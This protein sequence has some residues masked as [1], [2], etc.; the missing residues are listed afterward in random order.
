MFLCSL[1]CGEKPLRYTGIHQHLMSSEVLDHA[2][3]TYIGGPGLLYRAVEL[4][5]CFRSL[6]R[7]SRIKGV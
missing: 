2:R 3:M 4:F 5:S 1:K 7:W 6:E